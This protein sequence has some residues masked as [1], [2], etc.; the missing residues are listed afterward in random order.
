MIKVNKGQVEIDG[1]F[2]DVLGELLVAACAI[3]SEASQHD[4]GFIKGYLPGGLQM[5][6]D[7]VDEKD[8]SIERMK[9]R[10]NGYWED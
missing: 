9:R 5:T 10:F 3:Y 6:F 1:D 8:N 2:E 4:K 7:F